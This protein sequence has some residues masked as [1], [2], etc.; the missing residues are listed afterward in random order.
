M[1]HEH[2]KDY[3]IDSSFIGDL[4]SGFYFYRKYADFAMWFLL[5]LICAENIE[6]L[7]P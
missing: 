6:G 7:V 5:D 2:Y 4:H 1:H 3:L